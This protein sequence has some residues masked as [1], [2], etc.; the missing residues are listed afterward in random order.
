M[1]RQ[2]T[3]E[4]FEDFLQ[5]QAAAHRIYPSDFLWQNIQQQMHGKTKWPA[6]S[7]AALIVLAL[8][9]V[10]TLFIQPDEGVLKTING[11]YTSL[12]QN[13][14]ADFSNQLATNNI[15]YQ[16]IQHAKENMGGLPVQQPMIEET[17]NRLYVSPSATMQ[18]VRYSTANTDMDL[19]T[20]AS[21]P[22]QI[23]TQE[24]PVI[25]AFGNN[26]AADEV[27]LNSALKRSL[28][29]ATT[30]NLMD[31]KAVE[32]T[33][34][35]PWEVQFYYARS[36][37]FRRLLD[38]NARDFANNGLPLN[39]SYHTDVNS[40]V[41]HKPSTGMELGFSL[42]YRLNRSLTLKTGLQYNVRQYE[43]ETFVYNYEPAAIQ[44]I[45][46][47]QMNTVTRFKNNTGAFPVTLSNKYNE[48]SIPFGIDWKSSF[49][50]RIAW[51]IGA[52]VQPTYV[53]SKT[54]QLLTSD[55]NH[56][57]DGSDLL[58]EFNINTSVET[59]ITYKSGGLKWQIGPQ[60]RYQQ[61]PT[62][63]NKYPVREF[64][65]D[66]GIKVGVSKAIY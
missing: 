16:T 30:H 10:G 42:G 52:T 14:E 56:Y 20:A 23:T 60:F 26:S 21:V 32:K 22:Q 43:M 61:L 2:R 18:P 4:N 47:Q 27:A 34:S 66:Y 6:L 40:M 3:Y 64:L 1:K 53:F 38:D 63:S 19:I 31:E 25:K 33:K 8:L 41:R 65:F 46:N 13:K 45:D 15:T 48:I 36:A 5:K 39:P 9:T 59:F 54:P 49:T 44:L 51:G 57:A 17:H 24:M 11:H 58:R 50:N 12:T 7:I 35:N 29:S 55:F 62:Y 37:T 28:N